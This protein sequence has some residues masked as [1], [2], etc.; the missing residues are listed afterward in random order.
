MLMK[1]MMRWVVYLCIGL[2]IGFWINQMISEPETEQSA[3]SS[4]IKTALQ[5]PAG[6]IGGDFELI[7]GMGQAVN[8]AAYSDKYKLVFFGFTYC[9]MVCP[10]ELQKIAVVMDELGDEKAKKL[11]PLFI[12]V[13]PERD[14]PDVVGAYVTQFHPSFVGLTGSQEQI[15]QVKDTFRV[16]SK[17]VENDFMDEYMVDHS[18]FLYFT[19]RNNNVIAV[20]PAK[21]TAQDIAQDMIKR[22]L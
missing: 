6:S 22:G 12:S 20:Y 19:D 3:K 15:D 10:T 5:A 1:H 8:N 17:K 18:A 2:A 9:P 7:D 16:Y 11:Q 4:V 13:D 21:E 14:T